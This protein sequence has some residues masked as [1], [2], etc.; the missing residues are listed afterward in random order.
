MLKRVLALLLALLL[1][2]LAAAGGDA[3]P[4]ISV[5]EAVI[6]PCAAN[7][8]TITLPEDGV[9]RVV[10]EDARGEMLS[11]AT[12][13]RQGKAGEQHLWWNGTYGGVPIGSIVAS[14]YANV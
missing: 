7:L 11:L 1:L 9:F 4:E 5:P 3:R 8:L 14:G 10:L 2:P 12:E 6:R 13:E